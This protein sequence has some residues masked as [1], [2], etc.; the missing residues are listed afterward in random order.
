MRN[1][2]VKAE[3]IVNAELIVDAMTFWRTR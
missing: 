3:G 2:D 1:A